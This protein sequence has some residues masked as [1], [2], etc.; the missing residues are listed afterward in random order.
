MAS[1]DPGVAGGNWIGEAADR[2]RG[3]GFLAGGCWRMQ[4]EP[5]NSFSWLLLRIVVLVGFSHWWFLIG[6]TSGL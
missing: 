5:I 2:A 4:E 3:M 1:C 6:S